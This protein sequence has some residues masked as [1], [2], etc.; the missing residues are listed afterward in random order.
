MKFGG[1]AC[2]GE[3]VTGYPKGGGGRPETQVE[4][5]GSLGEGCSGV[6]RPG[7]VEVG[8]LMGEKWCTGVTRPDDA[9][10]CRDTGVLVPAG[11]L[12]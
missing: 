5:M 10:E 9:W 7:A 6:L 4:P 1:D 8:R 3:L 11:L 12:S 2:C